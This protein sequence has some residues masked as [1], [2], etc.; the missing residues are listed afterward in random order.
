LSRESVVFDIGGYVGDWADQIRR[1][2]GT[3]IHIFE[4]IPQHLVALRNRFAADSNVLVADYGLGAVD[5]LRYV[6]LSAD[7]SGVLKA[8]EHR[9]QC[10]FRDVAEVLDELEYEMV[11]LMKINIEGDEFDLLERIITAGWVSR[12]RELQ[13]QFHSFVP[14]AVERRNVLRGR[15]ANT[16]R[17]TYDFYFV[18]EN[19]RL[20]E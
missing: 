6:T 9:I 14:N 19:W 1:R 17:L 2:Y 16:H 4:P 3:K 5:G 8:G 15:L 12:I 7:G 13:I 11:D 20:L 10:R 18:W